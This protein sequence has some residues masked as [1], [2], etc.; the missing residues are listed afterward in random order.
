MNQVSLN[1][2]IYLFALEPSALIRRM[3]PGWFNQQ[4]SGFESDREQ[5]NYVL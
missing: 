4:L 1:P 2:F 3:K 5:K